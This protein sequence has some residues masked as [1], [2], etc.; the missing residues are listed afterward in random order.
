MAMPQNLGR[1]V[2]CFVTERKRLLKW[3]QNEE[4]VNQSI[5]IVVELCSACVSRYRASFL[6]VRCFSCAALEE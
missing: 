3:L 6:L 1:S 5:F 4:P 2:S